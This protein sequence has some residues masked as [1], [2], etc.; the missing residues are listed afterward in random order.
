MDANFAPNGRSITITIS[1]QTSRAG[2]ANPRQK[3]EKYMW[4]MKG[5][6]TKK[7]AEAYQKKYGGLICWEERTP[8]LKLLTSRG[9]EYLL[10]ARAI[11]LDTKE[12][13]FAVKR[14]I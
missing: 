8:K 1:E 5:F 3:G 4:C 13:P 10:G 6:R 11:G 12:Y 7:E 2:A 9:K 14:R